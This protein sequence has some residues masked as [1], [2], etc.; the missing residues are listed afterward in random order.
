MLLNVAAPRERAKADAVLAA[1]ARAEADMGE[2]GRVLVRASGTEPLVRILVEC[3]DAAEAGR[4]A[5][6]IAAAVRDA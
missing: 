2:T 6:A 4:Y 1:I 5:E 3:A